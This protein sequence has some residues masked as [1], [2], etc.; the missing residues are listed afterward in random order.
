MSL[1]FKEVYSALK[2]ELK[3]L[4]WA[5]VSS[6]GVNRYSKIKMKLKRSHLSESD[7]LSEKKVGSAPVPGLKFAY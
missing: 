4:R 7:F 3:T 1:R 2:T 6:F 5:S